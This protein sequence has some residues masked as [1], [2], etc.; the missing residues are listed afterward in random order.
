MEQIKLENRCD[1]HTVKIE[2]GLWVGGFYIQYLF[3][4]K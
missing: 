4:N 3:K 1:I 2:F